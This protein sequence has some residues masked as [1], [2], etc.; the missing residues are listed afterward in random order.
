MTR[1]GYVTRHSAVLLSPCPCCLTNAHSQ[2]RCPH[3]PKVLR[4]AD[5]RVQ[6]WF[7]GCKHENFSQPADF[8]IEVEE[9][10]YCT[11]SLC[12]VEC[13]TFSRTVGKT[14]STT[15]STTF[16]DFSWRKKKSTNS[17][18]TYVHVTSKTWLSWPDT[19]IYWEITLLWHMHITTYLLFYI[20]EKKD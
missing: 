1:T 15:S 16:S 10:S 7:N 2:L 14:W 9:C 12:G 3:Y 17:K 13:R 5:K 18:S 6:Y 20:N 19:D 11:F 4:R 8:W